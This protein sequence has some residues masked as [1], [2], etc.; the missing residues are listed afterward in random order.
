MKN[1]KRLVVLSVSITLC[2]IQ[3][4]SVAQ[5]KGPD[6]DFPYPEIGKAC[7]DF[8]LNEI[9]NYPKSKASL[10]DFRGKWLILDFWTRWCTGCIA[11]FPETNQLNK[12]FRD[13]VQIVLVGMDDKLV[14]NTY[15]KFRKKYDLYMTVAFDSTTHKR[16]GIQ[17][18]PYIMWIDDKG[19]IRAIT[20]K[21]ELT[22]ANLKACI[23]GE[24]PEL[25]RKV[26]LLVPQ[27]KKS[28]D[29]KKPFLVDGNGGNAGDFLYR[30]VLTQWTRDL[31]VAYN[32][33][34]IPAG[35]LGNEVLLRGAPLKA[36]YQVAYGDTITMVPLFN[37][38]NSYGTY[39]PRPVLELADTSE[40]RVDF[41]SGKN[42]YCYDLIAPP[43]KK[44]KLEMQRMMQRDLQNYFGYKVTVEKRLMPYWKLVASEGAGEKLRAKGKHERLSGDG[45]TNVVFKG[46]PMSSLVSILWGKNQLAPPIID[47]TGIS[48]TIDLSLEAYLDDLNDVKKSLQKN[49]L[50]LVK[51]QKEMKVIVIRSEN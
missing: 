33:Y 40:F 27:P 19:I 49:G 35:K 32:G 25:V 48:H 17:S 18:Y 28:Y 21:S 24:N 16:F 36:L 46:E 1:L 11:S 5:P 51:G 34:F 14:R 47:E 42:I 22:A 23:N 43:G 3:S 45:H 4:L 38:K 2:I 37:F 39:W 6:N 26:D 9:H 50:D 20:D 12:E 30:S 41:T 8:I 13:K 44:K 15:E 10:E 29:W 31:Q 7:P